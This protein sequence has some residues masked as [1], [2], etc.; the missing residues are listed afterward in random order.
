MDDETR[1]V[2][3]SFGEEDRLESRLRPLLLD[4]FTGQEAHKDN[5]RVYIQAARQRGEA[6]DHCLFHGPP[7]LGKTTLAHIIA[8]EMEGEIRVTSGPVLE[9]PADLAGLL[10]NLQDGDILFIDEIHRLSPVVEEYLY[11]AMEDYTLDILLDKGPAARSVQLTLPRF[12][13]VGATTRAGLLTRPL[14]ARFGIVLHL[15][16]YTR[17]ELAEILE[18]SA[19]ML[20]VSL[21]TDAASEIAMR[22]RGTPR[23]ANRL[24]RRLRDFA[25]V[26]GD[27]T[28]TDE[29]ARFGLERLQVDRRG[30]DNLD[31]K[32]L[33][34]LLD[35]FNGGPCG[36]NTL[37][38]AVGEEADTLE[39]VV[40]P[41]LVKEGFINRTV[42]GRVATPLAWSH[43]ERSQP[44]SA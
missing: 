32:I 26:H 29:I 8:R 7:G 42:R 38:L 19:R 21:T 25:Q 28:V 27:G 36:L 39:D 34:A 31:R 30:L 10:T 15:E 3:G 9:K 44:G 33:L 43:L 11:P 16:H 18:R 20:S 41:F 23:V 35:K 14:M 4:E 6:L 24:L 37:A 17:A 40:E 13:L 2:A 1:L 5:L 12:T 22:S